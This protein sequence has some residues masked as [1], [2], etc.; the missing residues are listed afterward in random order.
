MSARWRR[1]RVQYTK[2]EPNRTGVTSRAA[3]VIVM[4]F[5]LVKLFSSEWLS[6]H[7]HLHQKRE[8]GHACAGTNNHFATSQK[9]EHN[10][11]S[12]KLASKND[13]PS[14]QERQQAEAGRLMDWQR[15]EARRLGV[16]TRLGMPRCGRRS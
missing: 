16:A 14:W 6:Q 5:V 4:L 12:M 10:R 1:G 9:N 15:V 11:S 7:G 13:C 2:S 8:N 3:D